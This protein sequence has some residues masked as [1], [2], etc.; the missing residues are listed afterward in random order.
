MCSDC[1]GG[2][3]VLCEPSSLLN[4]T[5][6]QFA[7]QAIARQRLFRVLMWVG[8]VVAALYATYIGYRWYRDPAYEVGI[9]SVIVLLILLN[10]RQNLRQSK[11]ARI[12]EALRTPTAPPV[13]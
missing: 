9:R 5:D 8:L 2:F 1:C 4:P 6:E 3:D 7:A 11:Y 13:E 10:A 12:L